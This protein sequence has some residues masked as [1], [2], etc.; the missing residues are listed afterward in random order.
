LLFIWVYSE[1]FSKKILDGMLVQCYYLNYRNKLTG[2]LLR[3]AYII[4]EKSN[5]GIGDGTKDGWTGGN[6]IS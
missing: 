4:M 3:T 5:G 1:H 6:G 2:A